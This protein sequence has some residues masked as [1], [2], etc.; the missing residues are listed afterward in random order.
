M[1][2]LIKIIVLSVVAIILVAVMITIIQMGNN[3]LNSWFD[4]GVRTSY[5]YSDSEKYSV[6]GAELTGEITK[7]DLSWVSGSVI[8]EESDGDKIVISETSTADIEEEY[9]LRYM[10]ENG[11]LTIKYSKSGYITW[12]KNNKPKNL[13]VKIPKQYLDNMENVNFDIVSAELDLC[14]INSDNIDIDSV[15]G[16][17]K[18]K[19]LNGEKLSVDTTSGSIIAKKLISP[20]ANICSVSG[21]ITITNCT[22][23]DE[24]KVSTISGDI[25]L[26]SGEIGKLIIDST[27]GKTSVICTADLFKFDSISGDIK[28]EFKNCPSSMDIES[29]SGE[30][31]I[32]IPSNEG[33]TAN[34]DSVSGDFSIEGFATT[35]S[36]DNYIYANGEYKFNFDSISGDFKLKLAD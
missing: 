17:V 19:T 5:I 3:G 21:E 7:L 23:A 35:K 34:Y 4:F 12:F 33:F 18:V 13:T 29:T 31:V 15:S 2:P 20:K 9:K 16:T 22:I 11:T 6:G 36:G 8:I 28:A 32:I 24:L 30:A 14:D 25:E 27:S 10:F 1:K 26:I